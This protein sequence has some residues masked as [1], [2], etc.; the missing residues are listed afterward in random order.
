MD[1][2]QELREANHEYL[3]AIWKL[4]QAGAFDSLPDEE[5]RLAR[6]MLEHEEYHNQ[7]ETADLLHDHEYD[8]GSE[9]N[10]FRY[11]KYRSLLKKYKNKK[12]EKLMDALKKEFS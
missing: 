2:T 1:L 12:P 3:Q 9:V 8:L 10:P 5:Q 6:I 7:F 4:A 11:E